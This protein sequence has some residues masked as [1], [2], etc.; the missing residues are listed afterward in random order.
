MSVT[1]KMQVVTNNFLKIGPDAVRRVAAVVQETAEQ[2]EDDAKAL[3]PV[4]TGAL[5]ESIEAEK[6][7]QLQWQVTAGGGDVDYAVYV[8]YGTTRA[9]AQPY[10][11]PAVDGAR[12][13]Y[14]EKVGAAVRGAAEENRG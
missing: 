11:N 12:Q 6:L 13:G 14:R 7:K 5:Q 10:F 1:F 8:E 4:D 3:V 9:P 2:I